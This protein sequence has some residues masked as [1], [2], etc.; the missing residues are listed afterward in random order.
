MRCLGL[1]F[2]LF[3][4]K[5]KKA[6]FMP[7]KITAPRIARDS[8]TVTPQSIAEEMLKAVVAARADAA[9]GGERLLSKRQ[10]LDRVGASYPTIWHWMTVGRFPRSR[11]VGGKVMWL[12]S[13]VNQWIEALPVARLKGDD[14]AEVA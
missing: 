8:A 2:G 3:D 6:E 4:A 1:F 13:E 10:V 14:E 7:I 9:N 5:S 11:T 12:E